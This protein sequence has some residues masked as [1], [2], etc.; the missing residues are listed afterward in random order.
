LLVFTL[1]AAIAAV[2]AVYAMERR[3]A[4]QGRIP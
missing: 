2:L 1:P 4:K 3:V